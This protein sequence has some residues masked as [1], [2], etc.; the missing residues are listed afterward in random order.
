M[1]LEDDGWATR[2][3]MDSFW[4]T[5]GAGDYAA[6]ENVTLDEEED[7]EWND[8][9]PKDYSSM[10]SRAGQEEVELVAEREDSYF[11]LRAKLIENF[12]VQYTARMV[13]WLR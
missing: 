5:R 4:T 6:D 13:E 2:H 3:K 10:R 1:L 7:D 9:D 8:G 12:A 11:E